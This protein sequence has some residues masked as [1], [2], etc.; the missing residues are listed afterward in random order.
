VQVE[1]LVF[2]V[3]WFWFFGG[4]LG[5]PVVGFAGGFGFEWLM[6]VLFLVLVP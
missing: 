3:W 1:S 6:I 4:L 2:A 5:A